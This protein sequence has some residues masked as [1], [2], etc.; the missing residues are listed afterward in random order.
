SLED[1]AVPISK[2][3][4]RLRHRI[5]ATVSVVVCLSPKDKA[6]PIPGSP[7]VPGLTGGAYLTNTYADVTLICERYSKIAEKQKNVLIL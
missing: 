2:K 1:K 4:F 7:A 5:V 3:V 6:V